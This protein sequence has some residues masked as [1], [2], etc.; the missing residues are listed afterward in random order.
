MTGEFAIAVHAL[1][2]LN[3]KGCTISS[4]ALAKNV[5]TNPARIRKVM[6][7][8]KRAGLV[9]TK[10][11]ADGGYFTKL[12]PEQLNL[13]RI[14]EA[15]AEPVVA[16]AWRSGDQ[17]LACLIASGMAE[18]LDGVYAEL[19]EACL[20]RMEEITIRDLDRRIFG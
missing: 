8:L 5:C 15:L 11:G 16:A 12:P 14:N 7:K 2:F 18:V 6:L 13:R 1:V 4:E 3:H 20:K 19:N 10:E 17:H 9:H